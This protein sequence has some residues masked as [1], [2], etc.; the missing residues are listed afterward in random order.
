MTTLLK[1]LA[2]DDIRQMSEGRTACTCGRS[3]ARLDGTVVELQGPGRIL[4]PADD[5]TTV[6]GIPWTEMPEEPLVVRRA[7]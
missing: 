2:C 3:M 4:V 7:A 1:C 5:L 6:D